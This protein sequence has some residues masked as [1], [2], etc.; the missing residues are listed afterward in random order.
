VSSATTLSDGVDMDEERLRTANSQV[1]DTGAQGVGS[2]RDCRF[3][4]WIV[5]VIPPPPVTVGGAEP[6]PQVYPG[7]LRG[8]R[9]AAGL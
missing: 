7:I 9:A 4:H 3:K 8:V 2:G 5:R 6:W 1:A